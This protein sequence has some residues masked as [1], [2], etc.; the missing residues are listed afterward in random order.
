MWNNYWGS[1]RPRRDLP[2]VNYNEDSEE[3]SPLTSPA[4]PPVSRAGSPPLLAV[5]QLNDNVDE[6]LEQVKRTL[7]NIGHTPLFRKP[8][9]KEEVEEGGFVA[10]GPTGAEV[11]ADN[12]PDPPAAVR[13]DQAGGEDDG[14]VYKKLSTLR[15][16][17][18]KADAKFWFANFE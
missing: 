2:E 13:Y 1:R 4:R 3:E 18:T 8:E 6:E 17:F 14:D 9:V 5:P 16:L 10:G 12:M 15:T 11:K 7:Q